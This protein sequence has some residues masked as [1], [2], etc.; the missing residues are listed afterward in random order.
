MMT[1]SQTG[2][3]DAGSAQNLNKGEKSCQKTKEKL[4]VEAFQGLPGPNARLFM[5]CQATELNR[6]TKP[7]KM[8]LNL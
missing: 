6:F 3:L 1:Y 8:V 5:G 2:P 7:F 4:I